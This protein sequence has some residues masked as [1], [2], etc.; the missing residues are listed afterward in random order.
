MVLG[1]VRLEMVMD[2]GSKEVEPML[3]E[4]AGHG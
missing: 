3:D 4:G 1:V 2:F